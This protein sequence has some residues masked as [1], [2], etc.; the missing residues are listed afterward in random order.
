M[1]TDEFE[2]LENAETLVR[3]AILGT[4]NRIIERGVDRSVA[5]CQAKYDIGMPRRSS[6]MEDEVGIEDGPA[7]TSDLR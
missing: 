2:H 3:A 5:D 7:R 6:D 4:C 1:T